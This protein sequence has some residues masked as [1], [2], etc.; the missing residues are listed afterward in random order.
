MNN[1]RRRMR[2]RGKGR[3]LN[4]QPSKILNNIKFN[5]YNDDYEDEDDYSYNKTRRRFNHPNPK[6]TYDEA[7]YVLKELFENDSDVSFSSFEDC[8]GDLLNSGKIKIDIEKYKNLN[9]TAITDGIKEHIHSTASLHAN[10]DENGNI[11]AYIIFPIDSFE[12]EYVNDNYK[13]RLLYG[14]KSSSCFLKC[15]R[16]TYNIFWYLCL[17]LILV[18]LYTLYNRFM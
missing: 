7:I 11:E 13:K 4:I 17:I 14:K 2:N 3:G 1:E 16:Y 9:I 18:G 10:E 8:D 5:S 6:D 15:K 12:R